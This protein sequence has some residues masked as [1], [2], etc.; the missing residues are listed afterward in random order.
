VKPDPKAVFVEYAV[1][2][3]PFPLKGKTRIAFRG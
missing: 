1:E 3:G 2:T